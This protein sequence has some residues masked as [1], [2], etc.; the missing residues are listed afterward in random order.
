[1]NDFIEP[2]TSGPVDD[3]STPSSQRYKHDFP[4][5]ASVQADGTTRFRVWAPSAERLD[6]VIDDSKRGMDHEG[7]GWFSLTVAAP[8]GTRYRYA[9]HDGMHFADPASRMQDHDVHHP[10]V[11][12]DPKDF[13]WRNTQWRGRPWHESVIYE[14]HPGT[15][16]GFAGIQARLPEL[17]RLGITMVELMP[18]ADFPGRHNWGYDGVLPYAPDRAYG[19]PDELKAM[20]DAAHGLGIGVMLDVVYNHFGPD[21][22]YIHAFARKFFREDVHTPW[23]AAIDFRRTEVR[24]YFLQNV[25]YWLMEYRFDGLRFDAVHAIGDENF[26]IELARITRGRV[27]PGRHIALV[28]EHEKNRAALLGGAPRFDAQWADDFHHAVH[29]LLTG[30]QEGYYQGF[31]EATEHLRRVLAEGFAYQGEIPKGDVEPRGEPS[32]H[33]P[34]TAFVMCLQNHDQIGNRAMGDRLA[35]LVEPAALRAA[36]ALLLLTPFVPM[37]FMGE[38]W[39]STTPFLFFTDHHDELADLV[40]DGRRSEFK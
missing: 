3:V 34:P 10:S 1:M 11:V 19:T 30:E 6:L 36:T 16:G 39:A 32:G 29:V 7:G 8:A 20:I 4:F 35:S 22:A 18:V 31:E 24:D 17:Q 2:F 40:R 9:M 13:V 28:L 12:V 15:M 23:G 27:E 5:G 21:G 38:E 14:L 37:L 33:L 25:A 26:L